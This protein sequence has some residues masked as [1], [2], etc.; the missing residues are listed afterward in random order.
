MHII[1]YIFTIPLCFIKIKVNNNIPKLSEILPAVC[2]KR[3]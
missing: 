1:L 2:D 3:T